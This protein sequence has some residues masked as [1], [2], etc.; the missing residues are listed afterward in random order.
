MTAMTRS[1]SSCDCIEYWR[2]EH[3]AVLANWAPGASVIETG[4]ASLLIVRDGILGAL[5]L[6]AC[7]AP[8][9]IAPAPARAPAMLLGVFVDDYGTRHVI[10]DSL[11]QHGS[12]YRYRIVRW[13]AAGQYLIAQNDSSNAAVHPG[14]VPDG[15]RRAAAEA[16]P[17][18]NR[19][20]PRT[21]CGGYPFSR[22]T[23]T[24]G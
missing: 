19:A 13:D 22:M 7:H 5:F 4:S 3:C 15:L 6:T 18:A 24:G 2:D 9:P 12:R 16:T 20:A 1:P 17:P 10:A 8:P 21:G 11:W 14:V 23:P